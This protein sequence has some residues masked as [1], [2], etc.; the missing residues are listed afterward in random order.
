MEVRRLR[1]LALETFKTLNDLNPAFMKNL[2]AK[3]EVTKRNKNNLKIPN[4]NTVKCGDKSIRSLGPHIC[5]GLPAE[6]KHKNSYDRFKE[7]LNT[8]YGPKCTCSLYYF[9]E[10]N[11]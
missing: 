7:Y 4:R 8:W 5:N 6:I 1:P 10:I 3:R 2:F 11:T 9:T